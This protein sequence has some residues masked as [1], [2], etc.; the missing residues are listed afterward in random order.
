VTSAGHVH[1][2]LQAQILLQWHPERR[3]FFAIWQLHVQLAPVQDAHAQA[4]RVVVFII[5]SSFEGV[6]VLSARSSVAPVLRG[7]IE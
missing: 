3:S 6:D 1:S 2:G 7:S 4:F 5:S